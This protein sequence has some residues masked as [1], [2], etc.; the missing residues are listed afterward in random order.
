[1]IYIIRMLETDYYKIGFTNDADVST[2]IK[3]LQ[4]GCPR[5][6][7]AVSIFEGGYELEGKI[8]GLLSKYRTDGGTE[9]FNIPEQFMYNSILRYVHNNNN[10]SSLDNSVV[11]RINNRKRRAEYKPAGR[12]SSVAEVVFAMAVLAVCA[13]SILFFLAKI[14]LG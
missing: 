5:K 10:I 13:I 4:T 8:Q 2:R 11:S 12:K 3:A 6:I 1:M 14:V 7:V 9:W